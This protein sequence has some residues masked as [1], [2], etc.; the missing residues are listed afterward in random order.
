[1]IRHYLQATSYDSNMFSFLLLIDTTEEK[2]EAGEAQQGE[3]EA[4][5]PS[6][7]F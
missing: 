3:E 7:K 1:M 2:G 4:E 5:R 6:G